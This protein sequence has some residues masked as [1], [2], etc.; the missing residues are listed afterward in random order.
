MNKSTLFRFGT[1]NKEKKY[2]TE[3][4][5]KEKIF[6]RR[7]QRL[8]FFAQREKLSRKI[9]PLEKPPLPQLGT[10]KQPAQNVRYFIN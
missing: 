6:N 1:E 3:K 5:S 10:K 4:F 2:Q 8:G 9:Q 7:S